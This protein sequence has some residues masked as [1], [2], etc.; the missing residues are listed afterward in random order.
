M[1]GNRGSQTWLS[2]TFRVYAEELLRPVRD[3]VLLTSRLPGERLARVH[4]AGA[5]SARGRLV[6]MLSEDPWNK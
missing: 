2:F 5:F 6:R 1:H 3:A 4:V